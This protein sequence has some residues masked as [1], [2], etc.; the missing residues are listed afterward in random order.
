VYS[1]CE[2]SIGSYGYRPF[3]SPTR[4][5]GGFAEVMYLHPNSIVHPIARSVPATTAAMFNTVAAGIRWAVHLGGVKAGD[6]VAIFGAGQRGI[7]AA[8]A[9]MSAGAG[10]VIITG[11]TR[12]AHKLQLASELGVNDTIVADLEN[13]PER[14]KEITEGR[15][16]DVVLD[17]TPVAA[18][19]VQDALESVRIGGTVVLAGLKHGRPVEL[20]TDRIIQKG[21][22]VVGARGVE[23]TSIREAIAL[24]ESGAYPLEKLHTHSFGLDQVV[25]AIA[26]LAGEVEGQDAVHVAIV[27]A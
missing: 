12:D 21:I 1:S 18:E 23:S 2:N 26:V 6:T 3:E 9:S 10:R 15:L 7:A 13:V 16:A 24:I 5:I 17:L 19:P 8:I 4:L 11:L 22:R 14:I 20:I 25:E 27:P